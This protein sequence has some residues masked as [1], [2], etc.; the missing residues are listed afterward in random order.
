MQTR[1]RIQRK[2]KREEQAGAAPELVHEALCVSS[3][4]L[5]AATLAR[6]EP[7]FGHDFSQVRVHTDAQAAASAE[8]V[9]ARAYTAGSDIVFGAGEYQPSSSEGQRL[10]AHELAHVVQQRD[11]ILSPQTPLSTSAPSDPTEREAGTVAERV[12]AGDNVQVTQTASGVVQGN[13]FTDAISAVGNAIGDALNIRGNEAALDVCEDYRDSMSDLR[14]FQAEPHTEKNFQSTTRLG[15]FDVTYDPASGQLTIEVRCNFKFVD[16]DVKRYPAAAPEELSWG[17]AAEAWQQQFI[18]IVS[19]AWTGAGYTFYCQRDW[20]EL[21]SASVVVNIVAS[22]SNPHFNLEVKK[23]PKVY[24]GKPGFEQS[25]VTSPI[26]LPIIGA[27]NTGSGAFDSNDINLVDKGTGKQTPAIHEAGH[28]LGLDDEYKD[29]DSNESRHS[30]LVEDEFGH[31]VARDNDGRIMST[32][33]AMEPEHGVTFLEALKEATGI[34]WATRSKEPRA[35]PSNPNA[36]QPQPGDFPVP[37]KD[38]VPV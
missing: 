7:H 19:T 33:N 13:W 1:E 32:G 21:L 8:A 3:Q 29:S 30:D 24:K 9:S 18:S 23:I 6:T 10:I 31:S 5:D 37:S 26:V 4:P 16:G 22:A 25:S 36:P 17:D 2:A 35:I 34:E 11:W 12:M 27:I 20:W 15:M 28:M 38:N 14:E